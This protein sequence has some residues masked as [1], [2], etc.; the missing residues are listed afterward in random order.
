MALRETSESIVPYSTLEEAVTVNPETNQ[1]HIFSKKWRL[2][3]LYVIKPKERPIEVMQLNFAQQQVIYQ[4]RH[5]RKIILKSRQQGISTLYI[6]YNLDSCIFQSHYHAGIQSYGRDESAKLYKRALLM[7]K[8]FPKAIKRELKLKLIA[9]SVTTGLEFSNGSSLKIGNFRGDTLD[10]LH[11]SELAKISKKYPEKANELKT[12]AFQAVSSSNIITIETTAEG[13]TGLFPETWNSSIALQ[14]AGVEL[15]PL[16]F[17]AI[18]LSWMDDLDCNLSLPTPVQSTPALVKYIKD[19]EDEFTLT[20][21]TE[22][23]VHNSKDSSKPHLNLTQEQINWLVPKLR[24]LGND[25]N[26]EYP[27]TP[28]MAFAQSIEGTYFQKQYEV[29]KQEHRIQSIEYNPSYPVYVSWDIG[30]ADEGVLLVWQI[31]NNTVYLIEEYHAV[32]VGVEHYLEVLVQ[33]NVADNIAQHFFPH[34]VAVKEWGSGRTREETLRSHGV[35]NITILPRLSFSE[36]IA[37]ARSM[38]LSTL[39]ISTKCR[40][41]IIAIQNY[42]KKKDNKLGVYLD[43]DVHD[44]HSNYMAAFRYGSQGLSTFKVEQT[45]PITQLNN[46]TPRKQVGIAL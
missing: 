17:Q 40:D 31:Y 46:K 38:L 44:I 43:I 13:E 35:T 7:W 20:I 42:R 34:D 30:V 14:D 41:T 11:V 32:G 16:D 26:R 2:N 23:I 9:S 36:S 37:V 5:N 19:L 25:F 12:G 1:L 6:A 18:F 27:A 24:E 8:H 45:A 10:S 22:T 3:H 39:I 15:T 28:R 4:F 33:L 21:D 29:I